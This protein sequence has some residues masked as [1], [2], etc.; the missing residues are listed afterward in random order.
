[1]EKLTFKQ[2][3]DSKDQL[4]RAIENIPVT[5]VEYEVKKYCSLTLGESEDVKT[6]VGL[7]PKQK[8]VVEW[9]YIDANNPTPD[10]VRIVGNKEAD[11]EERHDIFWSGAK[12]SKWLSR[13]TLRGN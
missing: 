7:K 10:Y 13:H 2:Y 8:V 3:L 5:I 12:L 9:H 4:L 1:M 6:V 11:E